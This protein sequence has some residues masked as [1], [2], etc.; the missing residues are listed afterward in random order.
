MGPAHAGCGDERCA[1][2]QA[3]AHHRPAK[4]GCRAGD[5]LNRDFTAAAP[6]TKWVAD[7][8]YVRTWAGFVYVAFVLDC[9][10]QRI[11]AWHAATAKTTPLVLTPLR[12]ALWDRDRHGH[13]CS[14]A[15]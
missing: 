12:I 10:S 3:S 8:T 1:S 7:F 5:L 15:S 11:L 2:R 9:Y 6:N 14:P 4:D 13:L